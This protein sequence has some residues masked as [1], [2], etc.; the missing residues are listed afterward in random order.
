[1][2][3][4]YHRSGYRRVVRERIDYGLDEFLRYIINSNLPRR[5]W[6]LVKQEIDHG[7]V[8]TSEETK[9]VA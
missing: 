3:H 4:E 6:F 5:I 1:M 2:N 7:E 9:V 8:Q